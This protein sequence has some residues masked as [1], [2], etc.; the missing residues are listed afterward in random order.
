MERRAPDCKRIARVRETSAARAGV[1]DGV[2]DEGRGDGGL[3]P[4][5]RK[6]SLWLVK[7]PVVGVKLRFHI[8]VEAV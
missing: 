4:H 6:N 1:E 3:K 8:A 2:G 5:G 7:P